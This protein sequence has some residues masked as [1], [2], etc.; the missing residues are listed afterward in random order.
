MEAPFKLNRRMGRI[1]TGGGQR[2]SCLLNVSEHTQVAD[3]PGS[4]RLTEDPSTL[5]GSII[6]GVAGPLR[7][8]GE[9]HRQ[10]GKRKEAHLG[11]RRWGKGGGRLE[12]GWRV[13]IWPEQEF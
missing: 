1:Q 13:Q 6:H 3:G 4:S 8:V 2:R 5:G 11:T 12:Q 9:E 7:L 10:R